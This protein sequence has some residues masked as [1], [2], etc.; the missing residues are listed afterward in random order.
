MFFILLCFACAKKNKTV[1]NNSNSPAP[2]SLPNTPIIDGVFQVI[3]KQ[4]YNQ[5][6]FITY[7][8]TALGGFYKH[9]TNVYDTSSFINGGNMVLNSIY[10]KKLSNG[11]YEDTT[12]NISFSTNSWYISGSTQVP[13]FSYSYNSAFPKFNNNTLLP[14]TIIISKS[15]YLNLNGKISGN[16]DLVKLEIW[17]GSNLISRYISNN[18]TLQSSELSVLDPNF[19]STIILYVKKR[20]VRSFS[21]KDYLFETVLMH[22]KDN[23]PVIL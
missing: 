22:I 9:K 18:L 1:N 12:K 7:D 14:D 20:E 3:K 10:L 19:P 13:S 15:I 8:S 11:S 4:I 16:Y 6:T 21:N 17:N 23:I 2:N 5:N